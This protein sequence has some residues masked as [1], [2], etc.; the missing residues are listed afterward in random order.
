MQA[1]YVAAHHTIKKNKNIQTNKV[2]LTGDMPEMNLKQ[3]RFTYSSSGPF[4][5]YCE[6][7]QKSRET[8]NWKH[9][10]RSELNKAS[11][12]NH[13]AYSDSK[14]LAKRTISDKILKD[15]PFEIAGNCNYDGYYRALASMVYNFF[16]KKT[17]SGAIATSKAGLSVNEKVPEELHEPVTKKFKW[18]NVY[19][20]L[21]KNIWAA[22]LAEIELLSSK[23]KNVKYLLC[24]INVFTKYAWVK[25]LIK[26]KKGRKLL[27]SFIEIVNVSILK[28]K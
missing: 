10:R 11:F 17:R 2:L 1:Y 3:P 12:A 27:N 5:K 14:D 4:I 21:K 9:L 6:R 25:P 15:R 23:N 22:N 28:S 19:A 13:A 24:V 18:K 8:G 20:R 7:I 26:D 16:D